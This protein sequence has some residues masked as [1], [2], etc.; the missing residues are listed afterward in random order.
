QYP[1]EKDRE[2]CVDCKQP[3]PRKRASLEEIQELRW[4]IRDENKN[5]AITEP[6]HRPMK[7]QH[8]V[9]DFLKREV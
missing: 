7:Q 9:G 2:G 8:P 3:V 4:T 5:G 6:S 1:D